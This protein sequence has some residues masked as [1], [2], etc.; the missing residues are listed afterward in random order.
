MNNKY[1]YTALISETATSNHISDKTHFESNENYINGFQIQHTKIKSEK[2]SKEL[3]MDIGSYCTI[4]FNRISN[5]SEKSTQKLSNI[6]CK[7]LYE[8]L[9]SNC[10]NIFIAGL[11]NRFLTS[12]TIGPKCVSKINVTRHINIFNKDIFKQ[13]NTKT[14]SAL[15]PGVM[16]QTGVETAELIKGAVDAVNPD[17]V[18]VIDS[19][20][21]RSPERLAST[22]QISNTGISPGSGVGNKRKK[23]SEDELSC[24]VIMLGVPTVVSSSTLVYDALEKS[25][26]NEITKELEEILDNGRSYYV[27]VNEIDEL[28]DKISDVLA[29]ALEEL[30]QKKKSSATYEY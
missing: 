22:I 17:A 26:I 6:V 9:P 28:T 12:D 11:G 20:C 18:I 5:L 14:I 7:E 16:S 23:I 1:I 3:S 30:A 27:T 19:L 24:P 2:A 8:F 4:F 10:E 29:M 13:L 25:G 15:S 21:A